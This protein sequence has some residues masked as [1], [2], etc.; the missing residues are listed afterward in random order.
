MAFNP[1]ATSFDAGNALYLALAS[2]LA[3]CDEAA[4]KAGIQRIL[5]LDPARTIAFGRNSTEG[6]V[7]ADDQKIILAFRGSQPPTSDNGRRDWLRDIKQIPA[8]LGKYADSGPLD[9]QIHLG[10]AEGM[11][12]VVAPIVSALFRLDPSSSL[13]LWITGH[14]LG[15]A[16]AVAA[17]LFFRFDRQ[18]R[19]DLQGL[20]TYGQPRIA[21]PSL[22]KALNQELGA[23]YQRVVNHLDVVP[24]VPSR[25]LF[26]D[27]G[28]IQWFDDNGN[29]NPPTGPTFADFMKDS[30]EKIL[31]GEAP[32]N[33]LAGILSAFR[34]PLPN[35]LADLTH[36]LTDHLLRLLLVAHPPADNPKSYLAKLATLAGQ[37]LPPAP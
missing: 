20:Y 18:L 7:A 30:L 6:F 19:R 8:S 4:L 33:P 27:A 15:G 13:P 35:P 9:A 3:Y 21:G 16:L 17:A 22:A 10:F 12:D 24:R 25:D 26:D 2:E 1:T 23:R 11:H 36:L 29:L 37:Q 32:H 5:G 31:S 14:S 28:V 34:G